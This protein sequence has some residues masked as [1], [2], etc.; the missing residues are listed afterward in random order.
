MDTPPSRPRLLIRGAAA[1]VLTIGAG[2]LLS[3]SLWKDQSLAAAREAIEARQFDRGLTLLE[4]AAEK[5]PAS[6]EVAFLKARCHRKLSQAKAFRRALSLAANLGFPRAAL[7]REQTLMLVQQGQ[8]SV[9]SQEVTDL[10]ATPGNDTLEIYEALVQGCLRSV[11][12]G[13]AELFLDGWSA[14]FP[15]DPLPSSYR[16][17]IAADRRDWPR[18]AAAFEHAIAK[19]QTDGDTRRHLADA[20]RQL[21]RYTEALAEYRSCP[22][23][24]IDVLAG[25]AACLEAVR[26]IAAAREAYARMLQL[27]P[28]EPAALAGVGRMEAKMGNHEAAVAHLEQAVQ[29]V[30][31]DVKAWHA[32]AWSLVNLS[33]TDRARDAFREAV[34]LTAQIQRTEQ[35]RRR[36][37]EDPTNLRYRLE[38]ADIFLAEG[39]TADARQW[40]RSVLEIEPENMLAREALEQI[41]GLPS[42]QE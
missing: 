31:S 4:Q 20:L 36:T 2:V 1:V 5:S 19:G 24:T 6:A 38:L 29:H 40:F 23:E 25:E 3:R 8:L 35:L 11:Q 26:D 14:D 30:P 42:G 22:Q 9:A 15:D 27:S 39:R 18:A 10:L 37:E 33:E 13:E 7:E 28:D 21:H 41:A 32:L 17:L 16:G 12:L 34:R